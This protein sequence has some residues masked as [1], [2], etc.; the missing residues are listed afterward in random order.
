MDKNA[1]LKQCAELGIQIKSRLTKAQLLEKIKE[2]LQPK[3]K[4]LNYLLELHEKIPKDTIRKVCKQCGEI[5][6]GISSTYCKVNIL[7]KETLKQKVKDYFLLQ[8]GSNDPAHFEIVSNQLDISLNQCKEMYAEIPWLD[9]LR[10]PNRIYSIVEQLTFTK[11]DECNKPKC[12]IQLSALRTW[13][14]K[15][16]C[17]KCFTDTFAEREKVWELISNYKLLQCSF[18]NIKKESKD[19]RFHYDHINMFD[20]EESIC[21]MIAEGI[22]IEKIYQEIDKCQILCISCHTIVTHIERVFGFTNQKCILNRKLNH[23]EIS[24][25]EYEIQL[26]HYQTIYAEI[27]QPIYK[28]IKH[29]ICHYTIV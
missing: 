17:D 18:C 29:R 13:K 1:L 19:E 28:T 10:R 8:D 11:C 25:D 3:E 22:P 26:Q 4:P 14:E 15:Q 27:M 16:I 12:T 6:H 24:K 20:K 21:T 5:G 2:S 9:L 23:N 7:K